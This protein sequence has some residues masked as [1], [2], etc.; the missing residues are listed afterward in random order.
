LLWGNR[1]AMALVRGLGPL[2]S[3]T[4]RGDVI[5]LSGCWSR[6]GGLAVAGDRG[7]E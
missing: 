4:H 5:K 7:R 6:A 3:S 2:Q 1:G